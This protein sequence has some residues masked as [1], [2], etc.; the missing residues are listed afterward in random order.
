[1]IC[2]NSEELSTNAV[3]VGSLRRVRDRVCTEPQFSDKDRQFTE[4]HLVW[5]SDSVGFD[6]FPVEK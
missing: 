4:D 1:M 6:I 2:E 5:K 3:F